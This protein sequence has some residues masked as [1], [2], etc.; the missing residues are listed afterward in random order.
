VKSEARL[1]AILARK[2]PIAVIFR[3]GPSK[4]VQLI[5]WNTDTDDFEFRQWFKGR[6]YERRADLSPTGDLLLYFAAK[7]KK[8]LYSWSAVS[9][10]PFFTALALWPKGNCW[11][12]GGLFASDRQIV[13]NHGDSEM[14]LSDGFSVP[15]AMRIRQLS[16][17]PGWGEDDPVWTERLRRDGWTQIGFPTK[18]K[19]DFGA[20]LWIEFD[21]PI[22]WRKPNPQQKDCAVEIRFLE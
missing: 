19:D 15:K 20:K 7:H 1:Y 22:T 17:R 4:R 2:A 13:L 6:I 16:G 12:G 21:P 11:G 18:T 10:P 3:R 14:Q 5:K 8:P 9:R